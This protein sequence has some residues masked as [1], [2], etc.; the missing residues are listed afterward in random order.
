M[1]DF[2]T[3]EEPFHYNYTNYSYEDYYVIRTIKQPMYMV[4]ILSLMF[5]MIFVLSL[6]G[7]CLVIAVVFRNK[8]MRNTTNYFIVNLA[9]AD[10]LVAIFCVPMTLLDNIYTG[11]PFGP[12]LCKTTPFIQHVSVCA[13]VN[14]LAVIAVDRYMAICNTWRRKLFTTFTSRVALFMIWAVAAVVQ[15]PVF[16]YH[17][18][19]VGDP[20]Y[21]IKMC[22]THW[23]TYDLQRGYFVI[24]LFLFCYA[25]PLVLILV[26]YMMITIRVWNRHVPGHSAN[27]SGVIQK[28]KIK[29]VKMFAMVVTLFTLSWLPQYVI[30]F[31]FYYSPNLTR[32]DDIVITLSKYVIPALQWLGLSNSC[33]N[34]LIYCLFNK[35]YRRGFKTLLRCYRYGDASHQVLKHQSTINGTALTDSTR[36]PT[37]MYSPAKFMSVE[38]SNG[39]MTVSFRKEDEDT[40]TSGS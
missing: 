19:F 5:G 25:L 26:C 37:R 20:P 3:S 7:N 15:L 38:Y 16:I 28:S 6:V 31:V 32:D 24:A 2:N 34:P 27:S 13:S 21:T 18:E 23:P 36:R 8:G 10:I 22:G 30:R 9:T 39:H 40:S 14:T 35:K 1:A 11:W 33:I 29:V 4:A 12:V 17:E